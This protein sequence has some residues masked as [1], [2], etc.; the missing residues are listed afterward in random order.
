MRNLSAPPPMDSKLSFGSVNSVQIG[1]KS[2]M[3]GHIL[4]CVS[5]GRLSHSDL[6]YNTHYKTLAP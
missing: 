6:Y 3:H 2:P 5:A 1:I 4:Y